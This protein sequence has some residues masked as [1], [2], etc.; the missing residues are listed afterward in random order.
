MY[1]QPFWS[2]WDGRGHEDAVAVRVGWYEDYDEAIR[3][4]RRLGVNVRELDLMHGWFGHV[5]EDVIP[6]ACTEL[7]E[8][9]AEPDTYVDPES[10]VKA[11]F[12]FVVVQ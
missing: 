8:C 7:G 3:D 1:A 2:E 11:T 6:D 4:I 10:M 5:D 9:L 12:A